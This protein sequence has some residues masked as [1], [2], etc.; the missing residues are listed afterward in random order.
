M[1]MPFITTLH[2]NELNC[3]YFSVTLPND[4]QAISPPS[5]TQGLTSAVFSKNASSTTVAILVGQRHGT[6][7]KTIAKYFASQFKAYQ[8]PEEKKSRYTF[9]YTQQG[10]QC[11]AWVSTQDEIF[12]VI[13]LIGNPREAMNFVKNNITSKTYTK[14]IP[15]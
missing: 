12:M 8:N 7:A 4:W 11:Q 9:N 10:L 2:A 5:E 15:E 1:Y 3:P 14:L 13:S 6:D